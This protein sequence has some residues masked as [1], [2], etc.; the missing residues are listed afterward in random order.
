MGTF[1][2]N[3]LEGIFGIGFLGA[4]VPCFFIYMASN[5][6]SMSSMIFTARLFGDYSLLAGIISLVI[7]CLLLFLNILRSRNSKSKGTPT[8]H[9][10]LGFCAVGVCILISLL[11]PI[12]I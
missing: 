11:I 7:G 8:L 3:K 10:L 5:L 6:I 1:D 2:M 4:A 9:V 12:F